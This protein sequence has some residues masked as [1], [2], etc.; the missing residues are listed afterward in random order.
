MYQLKKQDSWQLRCDCGFNSMIESN[1]SINHTIIT[2]CC[3]GTLSRIRRDFDAIRYRTPSL[4]T[5]KYIHVKYLHYNY[6]G[7]SNDSILINVAFKA[8]KRKV[9]SQIKNEKAGRYIHLILT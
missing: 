6:V 3:S 2:Q 7:A 9:L 8:K 4:L 5:W 1:D